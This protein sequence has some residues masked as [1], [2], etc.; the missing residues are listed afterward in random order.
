M[1]IVCLCVFS[2][3]YGRTESILAH[4]TEAMEI[5]GYKEIS[6]GVVS[7]DGVIIVYSNPRCSRRPNKEQ[8]GEHTSH[9][10]SVCAIPKVWIVPAAEMDTGWWVDLFAFRPAQSQVL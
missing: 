2:G 5:T 3:T 10:L 9:E 1:F 4:S 8:H 6:C 7:Y